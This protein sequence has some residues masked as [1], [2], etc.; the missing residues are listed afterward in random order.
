MG[1]FGVKGQGRLRSF[2]QDPA[3]LFDYT[4]LTDETGARVFALTPQGQGDG[5]F[6]VAV[7]GVASRE[8][9]E[10]LSGIKL[11]IARANLPQ[12]EDENTFYFADLIGLE[13]RAPKGAVIG[14]VENVYDF[15][16]G[17][18]LEI[19]PQQGASFMLPFKDA[20]APHVNLAEGF[21]TI[22]IPRGW[23]AE[24]KQPVEEA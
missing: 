18:I 17:A 14:M 23:L 16:A 22:I 3:A 13:A 10:A 4:P 21:V 7:K 15:G 12:T 2:T 6:I 1:A 19:K 20:Y 24:E 5:F 9:M 8:E 11:Y